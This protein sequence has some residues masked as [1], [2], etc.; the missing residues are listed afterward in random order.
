MGAPTN[1]SAP[2]RAV[3]AGFYGHIPEFRD[4]RICADRAPS[5]LW[6]HGHFNE[7]EGIGGE[8]GGARAVDSP[9]ERASIPRWLQRRHS[10]P[11]AFL[12][13]PVPRA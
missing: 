5:P 13:P 8:T 3:L 12:E 1:H 10:R 11:L 4:S 9:V 7:K 2:S 6:I